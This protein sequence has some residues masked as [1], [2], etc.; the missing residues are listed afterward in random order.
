[1]KVVKVRALLAL[2][3]VSFAL[4]PA[5]S[6]IDSFGRFR[7]DAS[8][9]RDAVPD[10]PPVVPDSARDVPDS[11]TDVPE[12]DAGLSDIAGGDADVTVDVP[13]TGEVVPDSTA[14][15]PDSTTD[16]PDSSDVVP[17]SSADIPDT[18]DLGAP[19][20]T[21]MTTACN[22]VCV[23]TSSDVRHCGACSVQ[24]APPHAIPACTN[25]RCGVVIK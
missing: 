2:M 9:R 3:L 23:L 14:D 15:V 4:A 19:E 18:T 1:M 24:C 25:G 21:G 8:A 7:V 10:N 22:G 12:V 5:C 13:D 6:V 17:D 20:C 11:A 16:V